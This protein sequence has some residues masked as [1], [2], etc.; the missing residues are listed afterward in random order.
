MGEKVHFWSD[1]PGSFHSSP[2]GDA[3]K[4]AEQEHGTATH[5]AS[6]DKLK[7]VFRSMLNFNA[8]I[9][10]LDFHTHGGPGVIGL[11]SD[12]LNRINVPTQLGNSGFEKLF[13]KDAVIIFTGC[14]VAENYQGEYFL[15]VVGSTLLKL[16]GGKV[17]GSTGLG[18]AE[19]FFTGDVYHPFGSWVTATVG[20]GGGVTLSGHSYLIPDKIRSRMSDMQKRID[21]LPKSGPIAGYITAAQQAL[22][23][24]KQMV[25]D[26]AIPAL[27]N[28]FNACYYL[29]QAEGK[30]GMAAIV[31]DTSRPMGPKL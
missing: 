4:H 30:L 28:M 29:E 27:A 24:A 11:G 1:E 10:E 5:V 20:T 22:D 15:V 26:G 13:N 18:V 7:S 25:P 14:N 3:E 21:G 19:P 23:N 12:T 9:D 8:T 2:Q 31:R 17:K 16:N 6:L